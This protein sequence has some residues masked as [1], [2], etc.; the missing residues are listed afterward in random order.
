M[1]GAA[2]GSAL[3]VGLSACA[4]SAGASNSSAGSTGITFALG[5]SPNYVE[6]YFFSA[7]HNGYYKKAGL[8][9]KYVVPSSTSSSIKLIAAGRAQLGEFVG[10]DPVVAAGQGLPVKV[11]MTWSYGNLG[12]ITPK[13]GPLTTV[14]ALKGKTVG[15]FGSLTYDTVCRSELLAKYGLKNAV[16]T[17]DV[18]FSSI[19]PL[20]A[21]K[22]D[23]TEGGLQFEGQIY[24]HTTNGKSFNF[25]DY[26][27][28][29]GAGLLQGIV[30][31]STWARSN[32]AVAKKFMAATLQGVKFMEENPLAARQDFIK[33]FPTQQDPSS[34]YVA[35]AHTFCGPDEASHGLGYSDPAQWSAMVRIAKAG[36]LIKKAIP[37][38]DVIDNAYLPS[39]PVTSPSCAG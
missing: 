28:V 25:F 32:P 33:E 21:G 31:N 24:R 14:Q 29:C 39:R 15:V 22:V 7:L 37:V 19:P 13:P 1:L 30:M 17:V 26:S 11:G 34:Y 3:L 10:T 23:A 20:V 2:A 6:A 35:A 36:G 9:V 4:S 18:G 16:K 38:S 5:F 12:I 27:K 8:N